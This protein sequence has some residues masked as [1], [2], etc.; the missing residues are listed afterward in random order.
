MDAWHWSIQGVKKKKSSGRTEMPTKW[1]LEAVHYPLSS[2][3]QCSVEPQHHWCS[4]L[5]LTF[6]LNHK[7]DETIGSGISLCIFWHL[8]CWIWSSIVQGMSTWP[9]PPLFSKV[10][11]TSIETLRMTHSSTTVNMVNNVERQCWSMNAIALYY[12]FLI[13]S[14]SRSRGHTL[15]N[16]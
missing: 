12:N 10:A 3:S 15:N 5:T 2:P 6:T 13:L 9:R 8:I 7:P 14:W 11:V 16:T 1:T 4:C